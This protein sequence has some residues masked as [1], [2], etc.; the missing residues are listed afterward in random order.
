MGGAVPPFPQYAFIAWCLVRGSTGTT[1]FLYLYPSNSGTRLWKATGPKP[2]QAGDV[3]F[4]FLQQ[5]ANHGTQYCIKISRTC[6]LERELQ[7]VRLSATRCSCI[8][9]L[10]VSLVSFATIN[11]CVVSQRVII[12]VYFVIDSFRKILD[13][14]SYNI[15]KY[16]NI[17][18][19]CVCE[20]VV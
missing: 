6:R 8:A 7:T 10:W 18:T 1:F 15:A 14:P 2:W 4:L 13:T 3:I 16:S 5:T 20:C 12:V 17:C 19:V 9:I 11:L